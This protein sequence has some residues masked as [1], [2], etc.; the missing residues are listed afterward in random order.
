MSSD[1]NPQ[2]KL[3]RLDVLLTALACRNVIAY[4]FDKM[5]Q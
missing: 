1:F 3:H 2:E 4:A 5:D